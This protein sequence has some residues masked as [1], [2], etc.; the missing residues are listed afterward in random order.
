MPK[1]LLGLATTNTVDDSDEYGDKF[2][3]SGST[4]KPLRL[5]F[6][7]GQLLAKLDRL[8]VLLGE[9]SMHLVKKV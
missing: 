3:V 1:S 9:L 4:L 7:C 5:L 6:K 2:D 8:L